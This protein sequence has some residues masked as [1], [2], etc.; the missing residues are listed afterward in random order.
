M[1]VF[2]NEIHSYDLVEV[3]PR[4]KRTYWVNVFN[5]PKGVGFLHVTKAD[6]DG[7][8]NSPRLACV[9]IE[10]DCEEGEGL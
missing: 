8:R 4:I 7:Y 5:T 2:N 9:K 3:K 1:C 6:A 10:I